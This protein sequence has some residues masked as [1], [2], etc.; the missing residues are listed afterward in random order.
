MRTIV[1][2]SVGEVVLADLSTPEIGPYEALVKV[3]ACGI[4]NSTDTKLVDNE[5]HPGI[6]PSAIGHE[7]AGVIAEVGECVRGF[8][9][10]DRVLRTVLYDRHVPGGRSTWGGMSEYGVVVDARAVSQDGADAEVH[11]AAPKQQIVPSSIDS[12]QAAAMITLKETLHFLR[13]YGVGDG[14][15][16]AIVGTGPVAQAFCFFS[17][18]LG[19]SPVVVFGRRAV[20]GERFKAFGADVYVVGDDYP[21]FVREQIRKGGFEY[22]IE[23]V[24]S[25]EALSRCL[26]LAGPSGQ[27]RVYGI[28]PVSHSW[29][30]EDLKHPRV[31]RMGAKENQVHDEMLQMVA[32]G[33]VNLDDWVSHVLPVE[34]YERAFEM[35]RSKQATKLVLTFHPDGYR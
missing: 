22:T 16:V 8:S 5:F 13:T 3:E 14:D 2:P 10:G 29:Y 11:W 34:E 6:F 21:A 35:V 33:R 26:E 18:L 17:K 7:S 15:P 4:C 24:G 30:E 20:H 27:L 12:V 28:A 25:R 9:V 31:Q 23:A 1:A 19:A 32:D